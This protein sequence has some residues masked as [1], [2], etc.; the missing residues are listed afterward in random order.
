M[1]KLVSI[2]ISPKKGMQKKPI[3]QCNLV[4]DIGLDGDA[5]AGSGSRQVSLLNIE[6]I[7][8]ANLN[9]GDFAENLTI[10]GINLKNISVGTRIKI[11]DNAML[12]VSQIGK[13][14][15][16]RCAIYQKISDC[17]M[18]KQGVFARVIVGGIIKTGD[19]IEFKL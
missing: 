2:N 6:D 11:G 19:A 15:H 16:T 5:H 12:E 14:C 13:E 18:P 1:A 10:A 3:T 4:K 9:P 8:S 17:I 7:R